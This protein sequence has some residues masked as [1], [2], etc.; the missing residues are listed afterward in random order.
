MLPRGGYPFRFGSMG[1]GA[2]DVSR[3]PPSSLV[4]G[5]VLSLG[6]SD[7]LPLLLGGPLIYQVPGSGL[8]A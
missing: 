1:H 7:S 8:A 5:D 3:R 6:K 4:I 2:W